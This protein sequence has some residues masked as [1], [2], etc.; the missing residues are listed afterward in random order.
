[1][2]LPK[3]D[4]SPR[5]YD[6]AWMLPLGLLLICCFPFLYLLEWLRPIWSKRSPLSAMPTKGIEQHHMRSLEISRQTGAFYRRHPL[7]G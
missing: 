5:W 2:S 7:D 4:C 1:M 6:F 3:Q